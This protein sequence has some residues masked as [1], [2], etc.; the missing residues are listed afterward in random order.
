MRS[1]S[2]R[3]SAAI[4]YYTAMLDSSHHTETYA[5][6]QAAA[7]QIPPQPTLYMHG[8][9]DGAMGVDSIEGAA[10]LLAE[11]SEC[12]VVERAGHFLHLEKPDE[13]R[14]NILRFLSQ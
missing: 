6:A 8:L 11:G 14:S 1:C 2:E 12:V 10:A 13:V 5:S 4:S 3:M 9:Q 7:S